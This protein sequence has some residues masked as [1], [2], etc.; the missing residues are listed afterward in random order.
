MDSRSAESRE[1]TRDFALAAAG[2][3]ALLLIGYF[4]GWSM[5]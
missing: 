2:V 5:A 1:V 3:L 4:A